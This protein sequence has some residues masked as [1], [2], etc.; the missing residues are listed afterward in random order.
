MLEVSQCVA[1]TCTT[2]HPLRGTAAAVLVTQAVSDPQAAAPTPAFHPPAHLRAHAH[3]HMHTHTHT[4]THTRTHTHAHIHAHTH[5]HTQARAHAHAYPFHFR[6]PHRTLSRNERLVIPS[7]VSP[8]HSSSGALLVSRQC[9]AALPVVLGPTSPR[10]RRGAGVH[11]PLG[12][13]R[14]DRRDFDPR[15][16][17]GRYSCRLP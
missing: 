14:H 13:I 15:P 7:T 2:A 10:V 6:P 5:T 9:P 3:T 4:F 11:F 12:R 1:I 8:I 16:R 17:R